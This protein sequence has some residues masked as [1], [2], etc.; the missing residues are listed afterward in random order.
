MEKVGGND[1]CT[2]CDSGNYLTN[3][4]CCAYG[5]YH[6]GTNCVDITDTNCK[7]APSAIDNCEECKDG[8]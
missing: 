7:R 8:F 2:K 4:L 1:I 6:N 3:D 5:K